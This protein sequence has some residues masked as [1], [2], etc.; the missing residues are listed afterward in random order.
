MSLQPNVK[1]IGRSFGSVILPACLAYGAAALGQE[2][3]D[4]GASVLADEEVIVVGQ[5]PAAMRERIRLATDA[6]YAKFNELNSDDAYDI[7]CRYRATTGSRMRVRVCES[8]FWRDAQADAG[9]EI[10]RAFQGRSSFNP[11]T[12]Y[13][14]A[15]LQSQLMSQEV[16]RLM[17]ENAEFRQ[18]LSELGALVQ[19]SRRDRPTATQARVFTEGYLGEGLLPYG[20]TTVARVRIGRRP[21][22]YKLTQR[23]FAFG[24]L[25]GDIEEIEISCRGLKEQMVY[26]GGAEWSLPD[27]W[28][29]CALR[30]EAAPQTSFAFYEFE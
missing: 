24:S 8:N 1:T 15:R 16:Y 10:A 17:A 27:D 4:P 23:T 21:W 3:A 13:A 30:V 29:S 2:A 25:I 12:I 26:E 28:R 19:A 20:A 9:E 18:T 11:D 14:S 5:N 6:V 22:K 7:H